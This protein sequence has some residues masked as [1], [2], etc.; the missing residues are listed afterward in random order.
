[1]SLAR[2]ITKAEHAELEAAGHIKGLRRISAGLYACKRCRT[3]MTAAVVRRQL[4]R[5]RPVAN[6]TEH[7]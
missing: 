7:P 5:C 6:G 4:H 3:A 1:M 2:P